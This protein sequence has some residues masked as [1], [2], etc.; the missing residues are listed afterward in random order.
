MPPKENTIKT[1]RNRNTQMTAEYVA[2]LTQVFLGAREAV[3]V[4]VKILP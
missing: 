2:L 1:S 3:V 4:S